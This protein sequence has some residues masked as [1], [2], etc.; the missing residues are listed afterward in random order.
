MENIVQKLKKEGLN[1]GKIKNGEYLYN[2]K[3]GPLHKVIINT[4][5]DHLEIEHYK[6]RKNGE[7][8]G[9][10]NIDQKF[11]IKKLKEN[12]EYWENFIEFISLY[13]ELKL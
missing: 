2:E 1:Y 6:F 12:N 4:T 9:P 5:D 10:Q 13:K 7:K 8:K 3:K 11:L